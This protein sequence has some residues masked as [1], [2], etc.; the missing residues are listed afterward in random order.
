MTD[1]SDCG[2]N[3][4]KRR[5]VRRQLGLIKLGGTNIIIIDLVVNY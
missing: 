5:K 1:P 4:M 2:R 3:V